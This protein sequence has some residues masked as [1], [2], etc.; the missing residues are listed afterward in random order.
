MNKERIIEDG[1]LELYILGELPEATKVELEASL[2]N[3]S[4]LK[5]YLNLLEIDFEQL[6]LDNSIDPPQYI[7]QNLIA[8][9]KK[10][11]AKVIPL[12]TEKTTKAYFKSLFGIAAS[13]AVALILTTAFLLK[14]NS[15][16]SEQLSEQVVE[17]NSIKEKNEELT[18]LLNEKQDVLAFLSNPE[19]EQYILSGNELM[20]NAKLV[21]YVNHK[22]KRVVVNTQ[23]L[24]KLDAN[25]D[26]QLWADVEGEMINMG[27]I[28]KN[29]ELLAMTYIE[30]AE[31][32]NVTIEPKG[33]SEHPTVSRL[34]SNVYLNTF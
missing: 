32:L 2:K 25:Q 6:A 12:A 7:K 28:S 14:S 24:P 4:E 30:N 18:K 9:I 33:G 13:I 22:E 34:I 23:K 5:T 31:S 21:S 3:D 16:I 29:K 19:T 10:D 26:Y 17:T 1:L 20:P 11:E 27:V 8:S 15:S